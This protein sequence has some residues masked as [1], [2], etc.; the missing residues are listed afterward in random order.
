MEHN[1]TIEILENMIKEEEIM[2]SYY[3]KEFEKISQ[4]LD[5]YKF[6]KEKLENESKN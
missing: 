3:K 1:I 5:S 4:R 2:F 6:L